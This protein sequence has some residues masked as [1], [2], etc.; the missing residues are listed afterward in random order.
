MTEMYF[1]YDELS[2]IFDKRKPQI[3]VVIDTLTN[4]PMSIFSINALFDPHELQDI[5]FQKK[6]DYR[7][8]CFYCKNKVILKA[9]SD[10]GSRYGHYYYFCHPNGVECRWKY[11]SPDKSAIYKGVQEGFRHQ[12]LKQIISETLNGLEDWEVLDIDKTY[13]FSPETHERTKPDVRA[14]W[15]DKEI[16][17]EIQLRGESPLRI[18]KRSSIHQERGAHLIWIIARDSRKTKTHKQEGVDYLRQVHKDIAYVGKGNLFYFDDE[19]KSES[20][21]K[22]EFRLSVK[23]QIPY[24]EGKEILVSDM[25]DKIGISE[26]KLENGTAYFY[27]FDDKYKLLQME[28]KDDGINN[29]IELLKA[30]KEYPS[31]ESYLLQVKRIWPTFNKD[32]DL[33]TLKFIHEEEFKLRQLVVKKHILKI[34]RSPSWREK[35]SRQDWLRLV[36]RVKEYDFGIN[37]EADLGVIEKF[38]LILGIPLSEYLCV[39][40]KRHIQ[41]C[42]VFFDSRSFI[43]YRHLCTL[44]IDHSPY[45]LDIL[46]DLT[47]LKR[48]ENPPSEM[49]EPKLDLD[50]F[51]SWF[52]RHPSVYESK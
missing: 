43:P 48:L 17:F 20:I 30:K 36:N 41:S 47:I 24:I 52:L 28:L 46:N 1:T 6:K 45:K 16:A 33:V 50:T 7:F 38:L 27:D 2:T 13:V 42:H 14:R 8:V 39:E 26:L 25:T 29:S 21:E 11:T 23:Y 10:E 49:V 18:Q 9:Q 51:L 15:K 3:P 40:Q 44:A 4:E 22:N 32:N 34:F 12:Y 5:R 37:A 31:F 19:M 35:G